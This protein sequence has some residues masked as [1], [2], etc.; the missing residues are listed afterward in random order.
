MNKVKE[1]AIPNN[2]VNIKDFGAVNGGVVLNSKA[3]ANAIDAVA[4]KGGGK[5]II[6]AGIWLTGPI[7]LKSNIELH[8]E[9]GA[10]VKFSTDKDCILLSKPV[11]RD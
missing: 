7:I 10:V 9:A 3:I 8:A 11:L 5:E 4:K 1:P 6:P 2:V